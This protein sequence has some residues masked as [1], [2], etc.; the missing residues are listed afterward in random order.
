MQFRLLCDIDG[1]SRVVRKL[2]TRCGP[3]IESII[4]AITHSENKKC[5]FTYT[6]KFL[7]KTAYSILYKIKNIMKLP[8]PNFVFTVNIFCPLVDGLVYVLPYGTLFNWPQLLHWIYKYPPNPIFISPLMFSYVSC[9]GPILHTKQWHSESIKHLHSMTRR[10]FFP[11]F[12][13]NLFW[14]QQSWIAW[15]TVFTSIKITHIVVNVAN[16]IIMF[17]NNV[18]FD[19]LTSYIV[20][21]LTYRGLIGWKSPSVVSDDCTQERR[22]C[23]LRAVSWVQDFLKTSK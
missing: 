15:A 4:A 12:S 5:S 22:H 7:F 1:R 20:S 13:L 3:P 2:L 8:A 19:P 9:N 6:W 14:I 11:L 10:P 21:F 16:G 17:Q 18:L 23:I